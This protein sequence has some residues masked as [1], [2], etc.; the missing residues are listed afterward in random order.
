MRV[1][2]KVSEVCGIGRNVPKTDAFAKFESIRR[3]AE[4]ALFSKRT[5]NYWSLLIKS[6][7]NGSTTSILEA[8]TDPNAVKDHLL[9]HGWKGAVNNW[10]F[11]AA[12]EWGAAAWIN[13]D[14]TILQHC[15]ENT[16]RRHILKLYMT[17]VADAARCWFCGR[18]LQKVYTCKSNDSGLSLFSCS[19][20]YNPW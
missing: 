20:I 1:T 3:P 13:P 9:Y 11:L 10:M 14:K 17:I 12:T 18:M 5:T 6:V 19:L 16:D 15:L 4:R 8:V 7:A 2:I